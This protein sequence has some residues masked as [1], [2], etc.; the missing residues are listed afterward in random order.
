[1]DDI[2]PRVLTLIF[3]IGAIG[4]PVL[5][6]RKHRDVGRWLFA[7][8]AGFWITAGLAFLAI[9]TFSDMDS[10]PES[11]RPASARREKTFCWAMIIA[12]AMILLLVMNLL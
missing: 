12:G 9:L 1:M 3:L 4:T 6:H 11:E 5:A 10:L 8:L 7:T 2:L